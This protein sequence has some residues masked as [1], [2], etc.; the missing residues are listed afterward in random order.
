MILDLK[1]PFDRT[2]AVEKFDWMVK[3]EKRIELKTVGKKRSISQ[4]NYLHLMLTWYACETGFTI[5][6]SKRIYK[7]MNK[8]VYIY[9]KNGVSFLKSSADLTTIETEQCN[10]R[11]RHKVNQELGLY[12][13][14]PNEPNYLNW[15]KEVNNQR[16]SKREYL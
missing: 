1:Q 15:V 2:K 5:E 10:K 13:P 3:N 12:I 7:L 11:F 14:E 8:D 16:E 4:N 6:E 9:E